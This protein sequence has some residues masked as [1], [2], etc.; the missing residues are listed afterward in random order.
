MSRLDAEE[1]VLEEEEAEAPGPGLGIAALAGDAAIYGS[2]RVILKSLTFLLV[3]L[4]ARFLTP[5]EF[6]V[7]ELVL[8]TVLLVDVFITANVDGVFMR[9]YFDRLDTEWRRQIISLYLVIETLYP[10]VL[11]GALIAF[12]GPLSNLV[13]G[14]AAFA[15]LFVIA[16]SDRFLTNIVDL[17]MILCRARRKPLTFTAYSL[18]R[19]VVQV[20]VTL[21]LVAVWHLGVKGIL[22]ASLVAAGVATVVTA[23]EYV[24]DLTRHIDWSVGREMVAFAWPGILSGVAFYAINLIDRFFVKHYHGLADTGLYGV[25]FRYSQVVLI[26]VLAFRMG[27]PQ[28]HYSWLH[29]G[30]HPQM[31]ARG[32]NFFFFAAGMVVVLLA[33]WIRPVFEILMP[34]RY[35]D[36]TQAVAPLG[37]AAMLTG[38]YSVFA[39]GINIVKRM[40]VIP[41]LAV[42]GAAT[43]VGLN[44]LLIPP[45]SFVGAAW[46]TVGAYAVVA[47]AVLIVSSRV[48]PVPWDARRLILSTSLMLGLSLASLA[49]D[50]WLPLAPSIPARLAITLLYPVLLIRFGF[51]SPED[52]AAF[53]SRLHRLAPIG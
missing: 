53:R 43:A 49:V 3:P 39:V 52:L 31:L 38:A 51:F 37:I 2:A 11:I 20:V 26:V 23:R 24:R 7:L 21:L 15:S 9:F 48:Y 1:T 45:W 30:R 33:A 50:A 41:P 18:I 8:A 29:S 42:L 16:L 4:Y 34:E 6:G 5:Q 25:A 13:L 27:W 32:G 12:S 35:W 47:V 10:A 17:P 46:A 40:R 22:I 19:G 36:A 44:F 14:T 28:W